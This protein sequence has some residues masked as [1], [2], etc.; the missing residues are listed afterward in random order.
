MRPVAEADLAAV[1]EIYAHHVLHGTGTF[2]LTPPTH[3]EMEQRV[4]A[5]TSAGLPFLV[6]VEGDQVLGFAYVG[7][8]R[9]R[10]AYD[11]TVEDSIYLSPDATG[12]GVGTALLSDV[13]LRSEAAGIRQVIAVI[14][15]S[16][17]HASIRIHDK[18][19]F[20]HIGTFRGVGWKHDRWL[21]TVLMQRSLG[22]GATTPPA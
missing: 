12:R 1:T 8:Y 13:L 6:A 5:V 18:C 15:D 2:E 21:D 19:G 10:P 22:P 17:N 14:G 20:A 4:A 3:A 7:P 9:P 16:T 11:R